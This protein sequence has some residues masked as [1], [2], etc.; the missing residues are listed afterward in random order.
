M[1][2]PLLDMAAKLQSEGFTRTGPVAAAL[3][4]PIADTPVVV[5]LDELR[6]Y[7]LNP[8]IT[9]N[10]LHEEIKASIRERGLDAPPPITKRPGADHYIIRNGG[11]TR[12]AILRELWA[13]TKDERFY[14]FSC[15]FRPWSDEIVALTGHLAE[16]EL[17]GGLTFIERA[18]GV[19]KA[20][21]LY[22]AKDGKP[23]SQAE[24]A[25]RL[26]AAGYPVLQ[27]HISRMR[28]AVEYLLPAIPNVLYGGLGRH[29]VEQLT[30]LRHSAAQTWEAHAKKRQIHE[31]PV[32]FQDVLAGFD[33]KAGSFALQRVQDELIGQMSDLLG[34]PYDTLAAEVFVAEKRHQLLSTKPVS[35]P[36]QAPAQ[37]VPT[38]QTTSAQDTSPASPDFHGQM[39]ESKPDQITRN[40]GKPRNPED[41]NDEPNEQTVPPPETTERLQ[42]IQQMVV[43]HTGEAGQCNEE[44]PQTIPVQVESLYPVT[45]IWRIAPGLDTPECLRAHIAQFAREIAH[46]A[47]ID[48]QVA[49]CEHSIGFVCLPLPEPVS[50]FSRAVFALLQSIDEHPLLIVIGT[51]ESSI[52][53]LSDEG[54]LKLFRLARLARRLREI[55]AEAANQPEP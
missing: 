2:D 32:L 15:L 48:A 18:L 13:E 27:P 11:N 28:E 23:I 6:P 19:E 42:S 12:L 7:E 39:P 33:G 14:R 53:R 55:E 21:E 1:T 8:R 50:D 9:K 5:T 49:P 26:K 38:Q 37:P 34:V 46:E 3:S 17:H 29:Q 47:D 16:N 51:P 41:R 43:D 24:L 44:A 20:R 22:E 40:I 25:R 4:A 54:T 35:P 36:E 52:P 45:D 30:R 31:F 10:P